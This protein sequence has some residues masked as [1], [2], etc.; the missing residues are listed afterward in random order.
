MVLKHRKKY[1]FTDDIRSIGGHEVYRIKAVK[2]FSDVKA[3]D[4]GGFIEKGKNLSHY[5]DCWVYSGAC[6]YGNAKVY[7]YAEVYGY[8]FIYK[9]AEVFGNAKVYKGTTILGK[10]DCDIRK[11]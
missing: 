6:V 1:T 10:L 7:G 9:N 2:D 4:L 8:S 11:T 5:G 3:G